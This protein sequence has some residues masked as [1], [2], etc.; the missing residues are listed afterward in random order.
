MKLYWSSV[1]RSFV[2]QSLN[3]CP[4]NFDQNMVVLDCR[5]RGNKIPNAKCS[6]LPTTNSFLEGGGGG[7]GKL[8]STKHPNVP[9][10]F[11]GGG[12]KLPNTKHPNLP[13][14]F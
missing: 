14:H 2:M 11:W 10:H 12:G 9:T 3:P 7:G 13:T 4:E 1:G 5:G 8:P 6:N